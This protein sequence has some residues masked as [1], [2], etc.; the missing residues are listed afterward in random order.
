M[1]PQVF[2][3]L[4]WHP[5]VKVHRSVTE[6]FIPH[7]R[8]ISRPKNGPM[9]VRLKEAGTQT[10][11][12]LTVEGHV[13]VRVKLLSSQAIPPT[14]AMDDAQVIQLYCPKRYK[15]SS[16]TGIGIRTD[17]ALELPRGIY[18]H[19]TYH[20]RSSLA[21]IARLESTVIWPRSKDNVELF[22][23]NGSKEDCKIQRGDLLA[24][25]LVLQNFV[26]VLD[27]RCKGDKKCVAM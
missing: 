14:K 13:W 18:G 21:G 27:V 17:I 24:S 5:T 26:P 16:N 25:V 11:V 12:S 10:D 9:C 19:V 7:D 6:P 15:I 2:E 20:P 8:I 4:Q 3:E 22:V 23:Y 1:V